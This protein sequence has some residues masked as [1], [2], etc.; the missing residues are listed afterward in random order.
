MSLLIRYYF[1]FL[2]LRTSV[3]LYIFMKWSGTIPERKKAIF[4]S[5]F[6]GNYSIG[7]GSS[8]K[9]HWNTDFANALQNTELVN[10]SVP[11]FLFVSK[12]IP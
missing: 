5:R 3:W 10:V 2:I 11:N 12:R 6:A 8:R 1:S 4:L 7:H 9:S